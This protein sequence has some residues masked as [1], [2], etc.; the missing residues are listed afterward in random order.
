MSSGIP[1]GSAS[2][3]TS[4]T[5]TAV[6]EP[7]L[8]QMEPN[9]VLHSR[10]LKMFCPSTWKVQQN[11]E[12]G[13]PTGKSRPNPSTPTL[14]RR[15]FSDV[16]QLGSTHEV[17]NETLTQVS[18]SVINEFKKCKIGHTQLLNDISKYVVVQG[19]C[20]TCQAAMAFVTFSFTVSLLCAIKLLCWRFR[21]SWG[22]WRLEVCTGKFQLLNLNGFQ[23]HMWLSL[24][25]VLV[26]SVIVNTLC[27]TLIHFLFIFIFIQV[28]HYKATHSFLSCLSYGF[29]IVTHLR[30]L[31]AA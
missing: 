31:K 23:F 14:Q 15:S 9:L 18:T 29:H 16:S 13:V 1:P 25:V 7:K 20:V 30:N 2:S 4:D 26:L 17:K 27:L 10:Q 11:V 22:A 8:Q 28:G 12:V 21:Y 3:T 19:I 24:S 5:H 6:W